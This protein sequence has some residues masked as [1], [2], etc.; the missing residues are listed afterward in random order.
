MAAPSQRVTLLS[1]IFAGV[2]LLLAVPINTAATMSGQAL[3]FA[4]LLAALAWLYRSAALF[5]AFQSAIYATVFFA[6][7]INVHGTN[8]LANL[9]F[10]WRSWRTQL[11]ALALLSVAWVTLRLIVRRVSIEPET[12]AASETWQQIAT[13]L[14]YPARQTFDQVITWGLIA[15]LSLFSVV[16]V[17]PGVIAETIPT[18]N[19]SRLDFPSVT[20]TEWFL[21]AALLLTLALSWWEKF[22]RGRVLGILW[23]LALTGPMLAQTSVA[24]ASTWRWTA[25]AYLLLTGGLLWGRK[26][27]A[28]FAERLGLS[29]T[30][31]RLAIPVRALT[32]LL[33]LGPILALT[34]WAAIVQLSTGSFRVPEASIFAHW[35]ALATYLLPLLAASAVLAGHALRERAAG[36]AFA[37]G[38]LLN[39]TATLWYLNRANAA[40]EGAVLLAINVIVLALSGL[41][42]FALERTIQRG[43]I[44]YYRVT[45]LLALAGVTLLAGQGLLSDWMLQPSLFHGLVRWGAVLATLVLTFVSLWDKEAKLVVEGVYLLGLVMIATGIDQA[46][47]S[48]SWLIF[49]GTMSAAGYALLTSWLWAERELLGQQVSSFGI[50]RQPVASDSLEFL[51]TILILLLTIAGISLTDAAKPFVIRL[52][53]ALAITMQ[54]ASFALL[55]RGSARTQFLYIAALGVGLVGAALLGWACLPAHMAQQG[56][57]L[58]VV[59][60]LVAVT[61]A[62]VFGLWLIKRFDNEWS[63]AAKSLMYPLCSIAAILLGGLLMNEIV[64]QLYS[65]HVIVPTFAILVV[66]AMLVGLSMQA[67]YFAVR[68]ERDPLQLSERG[69]MSYVYTSEVLLALAFL[70]I[71]LTMPWLFTGFFTRYW[72]FVVMALA[73]V[74][75]GLGEVFRRR[76]LR[77]LGEPL[78]NTGFFLPLFP[79]IGFWLA[80]SQVNY[81][82]LLL[83]VG[84]LYA[85]VAALRSSFGI[86]LLA[87]LAA[88]GALWYFL[89]RQPHFSLFERPQLWLTPVAVSV[90]IAAYLNRARLTTGQMTNL[91]YVT[92]SV[93]YVSSTAEIFVRGVA[94]SPWQP[95]VLMVLSAAGVLLGML[96]RVRAFLYL[97][98]SF[99]LVAMFAMIW[100][101]AANFGWTWLWYV[102]GIVMGLA[103]ILLFAMFEKKRSE[104]LRL[105]EGLRAWEA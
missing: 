28:G 53:V 21:L 86:S 77:V 48:G 66:A 93:I 45:T 85:I 30:N 90:L 42:I 38:L 97:G 96:L 20:S 52:F 37:G 74:G 39:L 3:W 63:R 4:G 31:V 24:A 61:A 105:L 54:V 34:L 10:T 15:C 1:T 8:L 94:E 91:R 76:G 103:I 73:F 35:G 60:L 51:N 12:E 16:A 25:A 81:S 33:G 64:Q 102:T 55:A 14:M 57:N 83:L 92:L 6:A 47:L 67:I 62:E 7:T 11:L 49:A 50:S 22:T 40:V 104:L 32:L 13:Q 36:Y 99:L 71:R 29:I 19:V 78:L 65:Q 58:A 82:G 72:P 68:A 5:T 41:A 44:T 75:V 101:A 80:A 46:N 100:H 79:V 98:S 26:R 59:V 18:A 17:T 69:R 43:A 87:C 95:I 56:I 27:L 2:I 70:H 88:N 84:A 23:L 89:S 9:P